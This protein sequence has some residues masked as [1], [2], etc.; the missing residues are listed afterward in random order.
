VEP[1]VLVCE[2]DPDLRR[3]LV[4]G[5]RE[6]GFRV[7]SV[8]TGAALLRR[9]AERPADLLIIDIGLPD[10]DGRDVCQALRAQGTRTPVLFLTAR[11]AL[12]DRLAGFHAGG[13]DYVVKPFALAEVAERLRALLRRAGVDGVVEAG[14]LRLDPAAHAVRAGELTVRLTPTEF[15]L[16]AALLE[17][18]GETVRRRTL[19]AAGWP[20]GALVHDNTID[21]YLARLRRKLGGLPSAPA[22]ETVRGVGYTI[23]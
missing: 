23:T 7:E 10:A 5:L 22:I 9:F 15:R 16:L 1:L 11:D 13:D 21:A 19:V 12:P 2:D 18:R 8:P 14:G 6:E 4:A 3:L 17:R 20:H